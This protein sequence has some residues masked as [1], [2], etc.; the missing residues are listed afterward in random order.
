MRIFLEQTIKTIA[1]FISITK[2]VKQ[3]YSNKKVCT[4]ER[5]IYIQNEKFCICRLFL[6]AMLLLR[7]IEV[8]FGVF[9]FKQVAVTFFGLLCSLYF[10]T[11]SDLRTV[12][13][14]MTILMTTPFIFHTLQSNDSTILITFISP[15][16]LSVLTLMTTQSPI[17]STLVALAHTFSLLMYNRQQAV[18]YLVAISSD[19]TK[20]VQVTNILTAYAIDCVLIVLLALLTQMYTTRYAIYQFFGE[21]HKLMD[22]NKKYVEVNEELVKTLKGKDEFL[23]SISHELRNPL[24]IMNGNIELGQMSSKDE[25]T[26]GYLNNAKLS[27]EMLAFLINNLLDAGKLQTRDLEIAVTSI[28]T[29]MFLERVWSTTKMIIQRKNLS[30]QMY[31]SKTLP[32]NLFIDPHRMMQILFNLVGNATKFTMTGGVTLVISWIPQNTFDESLLKENHCEEFDMGL[33]F[34]TST[35]TDLRKKSLEHTPFTEDTPLFTEDTPF[36]ED[37]TPSRYT[38]FTKYKS[39]CHLNLMK[40]F[41]KMDFNQEHFPSLSPGG[42]GNEIL[43]SN[44]FIR[45][46]VRDT[47][48]GIEANK[49]PKLFKKFSQV[50]SNKEQQQLG[51]GLG[52]W[53]TQNLCNSMGGD[54]KAYSR[55]NKGST[56]VAAI[57][58]IKPAPNLGASKTKSRHV[59]IRALVIDEQSTNFVFYNNLLPRCQIEVAGFASNGIEALSIYKK[60]G[61]GYFNVIFISSTILAMKP[62]QFCQEIIALDERKLW[63]PARIVIMTDQRS[64]EEFTSGT[65]GLTPDGNQEIQTFVK[66]LNDQFCRDLVDAIKLNSNHILRKVAH[67]KV[68]IVDDDKFNIQIITEYLSKINLKAMPCFNGKE[69]VETFLLHRDEI[70]LIIMDC[71]MPVMNGYQTV[72]TLKNYCK[73]NNWTLPPLIGLTGLSDDQSKQKCLEAGMN[74]VQT[75]PITF[76]QFKAVVIEYLK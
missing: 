34:S 76:A 2:L 72:I 41:H 19:P 52:L 4:D 62:E 20:V 32:V 33:S 24:N 3:E 16:N 18:E 40:N 45:I 10:L 23:L 47:G 8:L 17:L 29:Q 31:F 53:I 69:A 26:Q 57:K 35:R 27:G 54:I 43:S 58:C 25:K 46:E 1:Y 70:S 66:P 51:T 11:H 28:N 5:D 38:S 14:V 49:L 63:K 74:I 65:K 37:T 56:F 64:H 36:N 30:G 6:I 67:L 39:M 71:E 61:N 15:T 75:K 21:K 55:I 13:V 12:K 73:A 59:A 9:T 60:K 44:G 22:L 7:V 50:S 48:L 42:F 68:L